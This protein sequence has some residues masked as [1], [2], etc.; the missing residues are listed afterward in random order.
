MVSDYIIG[1]IAELLEIFGIS[2]EE[3]QQFLDLVQQESREELVEFLMEL[4]VPQ[5]VIQYLLELL[6]YV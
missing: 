1:K 6:P 4:G 5:A 3:I 2:Q